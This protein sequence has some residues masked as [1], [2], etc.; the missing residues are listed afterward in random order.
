MTTVSQSVHCVVQARI[1]N[2]GAGICAVYK[3]THRAKL[4][5]RVSASINVRC[6]RSSLSLPDIVGGPLNYFPKKSVGR[7]C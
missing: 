3:R 4:K 2:L 7:Y 5:S 6:W 1:A